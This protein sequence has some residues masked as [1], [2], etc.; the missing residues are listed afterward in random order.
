MCVAW[1]ETAA[2][3]AASVETFGQES[4]SEV[5]TRFRWLVDPAARGDTACRFATAYRLVRVPPGLFAAARHGVAA[6]IVE[7]ATLVRDLARDLARLPILLRRRAR[8]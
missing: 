2:R 5:G 3:A 1:K 8:D 7:F 4:E 6:A